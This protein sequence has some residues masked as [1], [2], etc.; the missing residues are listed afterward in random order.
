MD[1]ENGPAGLVT[2]ETADGMD[3]RALTRDGGDQS[4]QRPAWCK[5]MSP[6]VEML[7]KHRRK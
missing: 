1:V 2:V 6:M 3:E 5:H 4:E 7:T